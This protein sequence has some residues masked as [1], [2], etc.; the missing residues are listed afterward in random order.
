MKNKLIKAFIVSSMFCGMFINDVHAV[1]FSGKESYY[2]TLCSSKS[3]TASQKTTCQS[4]STYLKTK[5]QSLTSSLST[6]KKSIASSES[7]INSS[8]ETLEDINENINSLK[9]Q[10]EE[11]TAEVN[12]LNSEISSNKQAIKELKDLIKSKEEKLSDQMYQ[13]QSTYNSSAFLNYVLNAESISDIYSRI[14]SLREITES[15]KQEI[16]TLAVQKD[17]LDEDEKKLEA[18]EKVAKA[19]QKQLNTLNKS[20][21]SQQDKYLA[22]IK[23]E[24]GDLAAAEK[25]LGITED[26]IETYTDAQKEIDENLSKMIVQ[27]ETTSTKSSASISGEALANAI[28]ATASSKLGCH[29]YWGGCHS[30]SQ[31]QS[32]STSLFDCSGLVNWTLYHA[33]YGLYNK[34]SGGYASVGSAV[35][36]SNMQPGDIITFKY[37]GSS[38]VQHVGIYV[39][40]GYMINALGEGSTC[41]PGSCA[42]NDAGKHAVVLSSVA[43]GTTFYNSIY[44]IR[45]LG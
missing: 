11:I 36:Y 43:P 37:S 31:I 26:T 19:K 17:L 8:A 3:L 5:T 20:L 28:V 40:N 14:S 30:T 39:G 4:F 23:K 45:R 27:A 7:T 25:K 21:K 35:S 1:N 41:K 32:S 44:A 2:I 13:M 22:I 34:V 29:Y 16:E 12:E 9:S 18:E 10:I 15:D 33:G 24:K 6:I 38:S 42:K